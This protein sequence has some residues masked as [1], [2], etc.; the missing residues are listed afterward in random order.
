MFLKGPSCPLAPLQPRFYQKGARWYWLWAAPSGLRCE[1]RPQQ[2]H[3]RKAGTRGFELQT[4]IRRQIP[5]HHRVK[6]KLDLS[7][8]EVTVSITC[9]DVCGAGG[10]GGPGRT[11]RSQGTWEA[12]LTSSQREKGGPWEWRVS[13]TGAGPQRTPTFRGHF[14][15]PQALSK[16]RHRNV[17]SI[18]HF[19]APAVLGSPQAISRVRAGL[20]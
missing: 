9:S 14:S 15:Q 11:R 5:R 18:P 8:A 12:M 13:R 20:K 10:G 6:A 16:P 3:K 17:I 2:G 7:L 19:P 1:L 4:S